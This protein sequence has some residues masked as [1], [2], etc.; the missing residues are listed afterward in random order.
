MWLLLFQC[1]IFAQKLSQYN[2]GI[3]N[4]KKVILDSLQVYLDQLKER[5]TQ[6]TSLWQRYPPVAADEKRFLLNCYTKEKVEELLNQAML[7]TTE[8]VQA[9]VTGQPANQRPADIRSPSNQRQAA[10]P[11]LV[12]SQQFVPQVCMQFK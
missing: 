12:T 1:K 2:G 3:S 9:T 11:T 7:Y 10:P 4:S 5:Q 8:P 6:V